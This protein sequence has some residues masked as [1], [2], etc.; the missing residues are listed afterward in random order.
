M[1]LTNIQ[2]ADALRCIRL[3]A[4]RTHHVLHGSSFELCCGLKHTNSFDREVTSMKLPPCDAGWSAP[5]TVGQCSAMVHCNANTR[6][7]S[8]VGS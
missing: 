5:S 1:I 8:V 6:L 3:G 2:H 7:S 4:H